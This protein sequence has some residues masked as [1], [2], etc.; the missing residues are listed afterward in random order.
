MHPHLRSV[1]PD[2][3]D[4]SASGWHFGSVYQRNSEAWTAGSGYILLSP[5]VPTVI[6]LY[7]AFLTSCGVEPIRSEKVSCGKRLA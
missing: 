1:D 6:G 7:P 4:G 2:S 5:A 3:P